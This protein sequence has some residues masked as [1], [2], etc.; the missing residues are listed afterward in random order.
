MISIVL[1]IIGF[2]QSLFL[3]SLLLLQSNIKKGHDRI[4]AILILVFAIPIFNSIRILLWGPRFLQAYDLLSNY[5][6]LLI[7]PLLYLYT[8]NRIKNTNISKKERY[9][10]IPIVV[11]FPLHLFSILV[12]S[13][14]ISSAVEFVS[15]TF[16][17]LSMTIYLAL[18]VRLVYQ[19]SKEIESSFLLTIY[20]F[21]LVWCMNIFFQSTYYFIDGTKELY[22]IY[23]TLILSFLVV[24]L[25]YS[26]WIELLKKINPKKTKIHINK[27]K[28]S[29][30]LN[31]IQF[32]ITTNQPYL[33][34]NFTLQKLAQQIGEPAS[35]VSHIINKEMN[36]SFP[37]F[38]AQLRVKEFVKRA[39]N[40]QYQHLSIRGLSQEVGFKSPSTFNK[41]FKENMN[42]LP[43][44]F[45]E[46]LKAV[47]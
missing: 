17:F 21:A 19:H 5:S 42:M 35:Y 7:G 41:A 11:L 34:N 15:G 47:S 18:S 30:I 25:C 32:E 31:K 9:H 6:L 46:S 29:K 37:K 27:Q 45:M 13:N 24:V 36:M 12:L 8:K 40:H 2:V 43:T 38:I 22:Q 1:N 44:R 23:A 14:T 33:N 20:G 28:A 39:Q 26:H 4:G 16:I 10:F 3:G